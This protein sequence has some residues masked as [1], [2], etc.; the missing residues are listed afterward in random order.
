MGQS[1]PQS[2][3]LAP[4]YCH[5]LLGSE[6]VTQIIDGEE[7]CCFVKEIVHVR[8]P[9]PLVMVRKRLPGRRHY[10][11]ALLLTHG[12]GQNR[13]AFHLTNR[14]FSN[15]LAREGFD[16]FSVDL[17]GHGRSGRIGA[18][19]PRSLDEYILEDLPAALSEVLEVS[20][21]RQAFLAGHSLGGMVAC[22]AAA[23]APDS[24]AGVIAVGTPYRFARGS[25]P[26]TAFAQFVGFLSQRGW[27]P[28]P[29]RVLPVKLVGRCLLAGRAAWDLS[30]LPMPVRAWAPGAM[31]A[32]HLTEYLI[33][34]FDHATVGAL[35][36]LTRVAL[37]DEFRS[38]DGL[39]DYGELFESCD[40]PLLVI[41]GEHDLL[42]P[43]RSVRPLYDRSR[44]SDRT[45]RV[46]PS[47]HADLLLG[48]NAIRTTWPL[49]AR[50]LLSRTQDTQGSQP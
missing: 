31:E 37:R 15:Y 43:P 18:R 10:R 38:L 46:V 42:A 4:Y 6:E 47:G 30:F 28:T 8:G 24:V 27:L 25:K 5:M 48:K 2:A 20:G 26:L 14:S 21:Q 35:V 49:V 22:A 17:R 11:A 13:Y 32:T 1:L 50:W 33:Q 12:F 36:Q 45:Y 41:A 44:S 3:S 23:R 9:E 7:R 16:V 39:V 29:D 40:V 19:A 34:S